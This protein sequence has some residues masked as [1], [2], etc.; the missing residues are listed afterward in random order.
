MAH[1]IEYKTQ[2]G[3]DVRSNKLK[4]QDRALVNF[5][6]SQKLL[7]EQAQKKAEAEASLIARLQQDARQKNI[8][9]LKEN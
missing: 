3:K 8:Y 2:G 9:N 7:F 1:T 5:D 4:L 6:I